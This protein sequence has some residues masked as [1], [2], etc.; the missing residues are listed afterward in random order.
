MT[1]RSKEVKMIAARQD[2]TTAG[3][4]NGAGSVRT[5]PGAAPRPQPPQPAPGE[6]QV[7]AGA[8]FNRRPA[9]ARLAFY[10]ANAKGS[11][12]AIQFDLGG[13]SDGDERGVRL[14]LDMAHQKTAPSR[15][16]EGRVP[17]TFDW[18]QKATV[19]LGVSDV[20]EFLAVLCG[21]KAQAGDERLGLYHDAGA[22][23][24]AIG[25]KRDGESGQYGL[26]ISKKG[27]DGTSVFR[28]YILLGEGEAVGLQVVLQAALVRMTFGAGPG[29]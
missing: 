27:K 21:R 25:F 23:N 18:G 14:F 16:E 12:T 24:T 1:R 20:C 2:A 26:S 22:V 11:G 8:A 29:A 28:G 5:N 19:K 6:A 17:A 9:R 3:A 10:H 15:G 4:E 13:S 7:P